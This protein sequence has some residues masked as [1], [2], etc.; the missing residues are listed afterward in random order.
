[1]LLTLKKR[2]RELAA[3]ILY[4]LHKVFIPIFVCLL[5]HIKKRIGTRASGVVVSFVSKKE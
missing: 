3:H 5:V 4:C 1:M 2:R